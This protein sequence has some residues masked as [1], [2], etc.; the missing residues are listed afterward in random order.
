[1]PGALRVARDPA[2]RENLGPASKTDTSR[3]WEFLERVQS[4][5][6]EA[7]S[8]PAGAGSCRVQATTCLRLSCR[9]AHRTVHGQ[10]PAR[11]EPQGV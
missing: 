8:S 4:C 5:Q 11:V 10:V 6:V 7:Q 9:S 2:G 1:M 3:S